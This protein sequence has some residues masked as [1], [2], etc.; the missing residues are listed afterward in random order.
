[1][2]NT[3]DVSII[4]CANDSYYWTKMA[5][6]TFKYMNPKFKDNIILFS[7][8]WNMSKYFSRNV[9]QIITWKTQTRPEDMLERVGKMYQEC[10]K[11]INTKYICFIDN[12]TIS[13][14]ENWLEM[15]LNEMIDSN[16]KINS[17]VS[18]VYKDVDYTQRTKTPL[19][20][21]YKEANTTSDEIKRLHYYCIVLD[22][23]YFKT[24]WNINGYLGNEQNYTNNG[25]VDI[26]TEFYYFCKQNNIKII[27]KDSFDIQHNFLLHVIPNP[28][29][30]LSEFYSY[31]ILDNGTVVRR[32]DKEYISDLLNRENFKKAIDVCE[33][34]GNNFL[35]EYQKILDK[36]D[37]DLKIY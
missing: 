25:V 32:S 15:F 35:K 12:D 2:I 26:G 3:N 21:Q 4:I 27:E 9:N 5:I 20:P 19:F 10:A 33:K 37:I 18:K 34:T 17:A 23:E 6:D 11:Q 36:K 24:N 31:K 1:M 7:D 13:I 29:N 22:N 14:S 8:N 28:N 30:E 16:S